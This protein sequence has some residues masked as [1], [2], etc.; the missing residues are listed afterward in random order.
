MSGLSGVRPSQ[1]FTTHDS[2]LAGDGA[3][4]GGQTTSPLGSTS[5]SALS[6][7]RLVGAAN[8]VN[9][10]RSSLQGAAALRKPYGAQT[11]A[12][13]RATGSTEITRSAELSPHATA[14]ALHEAFEAEDGRR[15]LDLLHGKTP[16]E[17]QLIG[18]ALLQTSGLPY[19]EKKAAQKLAPGFF[20]DQ[21]LDTLD[22]SSAIIARAY[23]RNPS[24]R[25]ED[26][27]RLFIS[28]NGLGTYEGNIPR[29]LGRLDKSGID[30]VSR[31]YEAVYGETLLEDLQGDLSGKELLQAELLLRGKNH[32]DDAHH[33]A[34]ELHQALE[35]GWWSSDENA[36]FS[37]LEG[38]DQND[39][40][41]TARA[42]GELYPGGD[43]LKTLRA[44]LSGD[45]LGRLEK[46][47][48][49]NSATSTAGQQ[50][51]HA[52][53]TS[54]KTPPD[55]P[56]AD[57]LV[58]KFQAST[59]KQRGNSGW[60]GISSALM[61]T[62]GFTGVFV[63]DAGRDFYRAV[64]E[65]Q[66]LI[67]KV[68]GRGQVSSED[69]QRV[70]ESLENVS[71]SYQQYETYLEDYVAEKDELGEIAGDVAAA[72]AAVIVT[73][74]TGGAATPAAL[75]IA[76]AM[77]GGAKVATEKAF[78]GQDYGLEEAARDALVGGLEGAVTVAT[79]GL[80]KGLKGVRLVA[81]EA[82]AAAA[83]G[84]VAGG[85][86]AAME[87]DW[88]DPTGALKQ[89]G[90]GVAV[91]GALGAVAGGAITGIA[92][93]TQGV[94]RRMASGSR[95]AR[96][97][98]LRSPASIRAPRGTPTTRPVLQGKASEVFE[99]NEIV[100]I[101]GAAG[102]LEGGWKIGGHSGT[103][104]TVVRYR[105]GVKETR[106]LS[107][108]QL[109]INNAELL[110]VGLPVRVQRTNGTIEEG[111]TVWG[112]EMRGRVRVT[113]Q[114][115]QTKHVKIEALV[116]NN[117][118][119]VGSSMKGTAAKLTSSA[120]VAPNAAMSLSAKG[121]ASSSPSSQS[122]DDVLKNVWRAQSPPNANQVYRMYNVA[123]EAN[124]LNRSRGAYLDDLARIAD[125]RPKDAISNIQAPV[126]SN[127]KQNV[128]SE[129]VAKGR[130]GKLDAETA[131]S[132]DTTFF[133]FQRANWQPQ[134]VSERVYV[135]ASADHAPEVMDFIVK[136]ILDN[137]S[138]Y[139][140][141]E[142][143]KISGPRAVAKRSENIVIYTSGSEASENVLRT[144]A[145]YQNT[146]A[147][148]FMKS[149]PKM[150]DQKLPG[151]AL[152][153]EPPSVYNGRESFGSLRAKLIANAASE[154]K[155]KNFDQ[156]GF[157]DL[158]RLRFEQAGL[159]PLNPHK[160]LP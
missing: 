107:T 149:V 112:T 146:H 147:G 31:Q 76:A 17:R 100:Q 90:L 7:D 52:Q 25:L 85:S 26:H 129:T 159:D 57:D 53:A 132:L 152:A 108:D 13:V 60:S 94:T 79:A 92:R 131:A 50:R 158:V 83:G 120:P 87:A 111:W 77:G 135:N 8:S 49:A 98:S 6:E 12:S 4:S 42:Y 121:A 30:T 69:A 16:R 1:K 64:E 18:G 126:W 33:R 35:G 91:G 139:P 110:P 40:T 46:A 14:R 122:L 143:V 95:G 96:S 43:L 54:V 99:L 21:K 125:G 115:G 27:D 48:T 29:V 63:D 3:K 80:S 123:T 103:D 133:R 154:A 160:N 151:V 93:G 138:A 127:N 59:A 117:P 86:R 70:R 5:P 32:L 144:I 15:V 105:G 44:E 68:R 74:A 56:G 58:G 88:R 104:V 128:I 73:V 72:S 67:G 130:A 81:K 10:P 84:A 101:R 55:T 9:E 47:L 78:K 19:R 106:T 20:L 145:D 136:D 2:D 89:T 23:M 114:A 134:N 137:P 39:I 37:Q 51:P 61:D 119:L 109:L 148:H 124:P 102:Q 38:L 97:T 11:G 155:S 71:H 156:T 66:A 157:H 45:S 41:S 24:G 153:A 150:T 75:A 62:V 28:L 36:I 118:N 22:E 82:Q 142:M 140:G 113:N 65:S 34:F 116:E 141:V